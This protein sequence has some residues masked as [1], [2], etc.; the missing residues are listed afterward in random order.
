M[1]LKKL[2]NNFSLDA[3]YKLVKVWVLTYILVHN[4][5][6]DDIIQQFIF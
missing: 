2:K 6:R 1:A 4:K 5:S 3:R